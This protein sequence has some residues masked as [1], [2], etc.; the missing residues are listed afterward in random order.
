MRY[1]SIDIE[2]TGIDSDNCQILSLGVVIEDTEN[3]KPID[4]LPS[5]HL[6]I[7]RERIEGEIFALNLNKDLIELILSFQ[8]ARKEGKKINADADMIF[9]EEHEV[10][11]YLFDFLDKNDMLKDG[12]KSGYGSFRDGLWRSSPTINSPQIELLVAGKNFGTFDKLFIEKL[13]NFNR[14][15]K[16]HNR[17]LDPA[18]LFVDWENDDTLP[19]LN[20]CMQRAGVDGVVTH[21]AVQDAKDVIRVLRTKY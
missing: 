21:G 3:Q 17:I 4:E 1:L 14:I 10:V 8:Q 5:L 2:T 12:Q 19:N 20:K 13:P 7:D 18:I 6:I 15:F 9:C 11:N 16:F